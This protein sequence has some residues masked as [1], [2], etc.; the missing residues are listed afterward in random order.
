MDISSWSVAVQ[1]CCDELR[2]R[3]YSLVLYFFGSSLRLTRCMDLVLRALDTPDVVDYFSYPQHGQ[4]VR[5]KHFRGIWSQKLH[6]KLR[7]LRN[8]EMLMRTW[9]LTFCLE[10][11]FSKVSKKFLNGLTTLIFSLRHVF[12]L[13]LDSCKIWRAYEKNS[14]KY[15]GK[16]DPP[17]DRDL[18]GVCKYIAC[19]T[20]VYLT[21]LY[22][23]TGYRCVDWKVNTCWPNFR[24]SKYTLSAF[25]S[26]FYSPQNSSGGSEM[27]VKAKKI[28]KT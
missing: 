11:F 9:K 27:L 17:P 7:R 4:Q 15:S 3:Y 1:L 23:S 10:T 24:I 20:R 14:R 2:V 8:F 28:P 16:S 21:R 12:I 6:S 22:D 5:E 13:V 19:L 18:G 25:C 26:Y